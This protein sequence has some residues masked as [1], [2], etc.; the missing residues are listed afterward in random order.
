MKLEKGYSR[1]F[2][3]KCWHSDDCC[4]CI[5][6]EWIELTDS[7][8]SWPKESNTYFVTCGGSGIYIAEWN[9]LYK[10]FE[11]PTGLSANQVIAW[12]PIKWPNPYTPELSSGAVYPEAEKVLPAAGSPGL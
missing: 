5:E 11:W 7:T 8:D 3:P 9:P 10:S 2:C 1:D 6:S 12:H 4:K